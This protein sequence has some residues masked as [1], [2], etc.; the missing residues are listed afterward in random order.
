MSTKR[1]LKNKIKYCAAIL[2]VNLLFF[3]CPSAEAATLYLSSNA[4]SL[5]VGE[6]MTLY[7]IL[8]SQGEAVNN[9]EVTVRF[10]TDLID[11]VSVS[12][13]GS[14]LSLWV[15]DPS[16]SNSSGVISFNGGIPTPGFVGSQGSL[17]SILIRAKKVGR[18]ELSFSGA[19]VRANDGLGTDVLA[20]QSGKVLTIVAKEEPVVKP[21]EPTPTE[22][23]PEPV[24]PTPTKPS[25]TLYLSS[26]THPNQ[27]QWYKEVNAAFQWNIPIGADAVQLGIE[28]SSS[29]LPTVIYSPAI[30]EKTIKDLSDGIWYFK[31]RARKDGTWGPVVTYRVK[32]DSVAPEKR[33][34]EFNYDSDRQVLRITADIQDVTS[35]VD[36]Y[37]LFVNNNLVKNIPASD[38]I[39]GRYDLDLKATGDNTAK[40]VAYD[41]A[42]NS[43]EATGSFYSATAPIPQLNPI[44]SLVSA[45]EPLFVGGR[46]QNP[47]IEV[48][49]NIKN[50]DSNEL[51]VFKTKS[52]DD[53]SFAV[54]G[55]KLKPGNYDIWAEVSSGGKTA[56]STHLQT[57]ATTHLLITIGALTMTAFPIVSAIIIIIL[58]LA[59]AAYFWARSFVTSTPRPRAKTTVV[60]RD[61][62]KVLLL[63]KKRLE[64]HL[65][66]LQTTRH[67]RILTREEKAIKKDIESDLDEIDKAMQRRRR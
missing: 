51:M 6:T 37:D 31:I 22:P 2:L 58:L 10:P 26:S 25:S 46:V 57:K 53:L 18:A 33:K 62:V 15:E 54:M 16:F 5:A 32:I 59:A 36:H 66:L 63:F 42:G 8:N 67:N 43:V 49:I 44:R 52:N 12:K 13:G 50:K 27:D 3:S 41:G 56:A 19:A 45:N 34:V 47:N 48:A 7:V 17:I 20:G 24:K 29:G 65:G 9:A 55:P 1:K 4:S 39:D 60:K 64:G 23:T 35:G 61:N 28:N 14:I 30:S 40:L 21:T 38:V 11:V